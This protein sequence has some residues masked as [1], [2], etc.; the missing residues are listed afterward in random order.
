MKSVFQFLVLLTV[1][2]GAP[3]AHSAL[4]EWSKTAATNA[5]ADPSINWSEGMSP[6]SVNDSARAMMARVAEWRDDIGGALT[7]TGT[8]FGYV[9][10][11]NQGLPT[12]PANGT[13][14]AITVHAT[15]IAGASLR[16]D[17]GT[18]FTIESAPGV[19]L[20]A[21]T[22]IA[23]STYTVRFNASTF[24]WMIRDFYG[25]P[26]Q[27]PLGGMILYTGTTVP[28]ANYVFPVGQCISRTTYATYFAMVGQTF[29]ACDGVTT[30]G[31]PDL[32]E[33]MVGFLGT[34]GGASSPGRITSAGAG[35]DGSTIAAVGGLGGRF[36]D[37]V[38]LPNYTLPDT[39]SFLDS[40]HSHNVTYSGGVPGVIVQNTAPGFSGSG[41]NNAGGGTVSVVSSTAN[42][43]KSGSVTSGGGGQVLHTMPPT[44]MLPIILRVL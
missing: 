12:T 11:T 33:R 19:P 40:G 30:F 39:I 22:L 32:R 41:S 24:R 44:M 15:N 37:T 16:A 2:L 35:V 42:L 27:V 18:I 36:I 20:A 38:N 34:M 6:S 29:S 8:G 21:D 3:A 9:V 31:V 14:L 25:N 7:T 10:T 5:T 23:G 26:F 43:V 1:A 4:W 17:G 13:L 28:S